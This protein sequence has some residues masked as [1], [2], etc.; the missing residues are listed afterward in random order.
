MNLSEKVNEWDND[1]SKTPFTYPTYNF[2]YEVINYKDEKFFSNFSPTSGP[3]HTGFWDRLETWIENMDSDEDQKALFE[4]VLSLHFISHEDMMALFSSAFSGPIK[5]WLIDLRDIKFDSNLDSNIEIQTHQKTWYA[6]ITDMN[7]GDFYRVN[8]IHG[9]SVRSDF[10]SLVKLGDSGK[11]EKYI[12]GKGFKQIVLIED[13]IGSGEQFLEI[14]EE[15]PDFLK[16]IPI[17]FAPQ[18]IC[19]DG[20]NQIKKILSAFTNWQIDPVLVVDEIDRLHPSM[21]LSNMPLQQRIIKIARTFSCHWKKIEKNFSLDT[22]IYGFGKTGALIVLYSNTPDNTMPIIWK[23][24]KN[25][26]A[27][28]LRS[29]R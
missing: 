17:L 24:I 9:I 10:N 19:S 4:F 1:I 3:E 5:R 2:I 14:V 27:L 7:L 25:W 23:K 16:K 15:F 22:M 18:I 6:S 12:K 21:D 28:F 11:I 13:F 29:S 26:N 8:G 20:Y